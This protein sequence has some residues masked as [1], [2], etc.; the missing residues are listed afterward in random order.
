[1]KALKL[2]QVSPPPNLLLTL[3]SP[4][5]IMITLENVT[6][7][8]NGLPGA[9]KINLCLEASKRP[10]EVMCPS[11]CDNFLTQKWD[12]AEEDDLMAR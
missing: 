1:M 5:K 4:R 2:W 12:A 3:V 11:V 6:E 10:F 9:S 8:W 7:L